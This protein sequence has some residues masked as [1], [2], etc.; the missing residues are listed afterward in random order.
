MIIPSRLLTQTARKKKKHNSFKGF[1]HSK[2]L[3]IE[4]STP[5]KK[6]KLPFTILASNLTLKF[7]HNFSNKAV[8]SPI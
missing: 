8:F 3:E 4:I 6:I 1:F 2:A 7:Y 5:H